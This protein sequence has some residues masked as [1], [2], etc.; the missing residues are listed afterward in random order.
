MIPGHEKLNK[1]VFSRLR[2]MLMLGAEVTCDGKSFHT[3]VPAT[4]KDSSPT[5]ETRV[6][7]TIKRCDDAERNPGCPA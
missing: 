4:G 2:K 3:L 6:R 5:E 7:G 1:Y